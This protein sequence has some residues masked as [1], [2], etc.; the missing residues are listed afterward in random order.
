MDPITHG[1][2][3]A[4]LGK[5][6]FS[7]RNERVAIFAATLGAVFPDIDTVAD[8][9]S[10]DPLAIVKYHRAITHSFVAL[11]FFALLL[12]FLTPP[13]LAFLKRRYP[14]FRGMESPSRAMLTLI[15]GIGIASHILLDGMTS[16]GTRMWYPI[17]NTRVAWDLV[18][19][20]DLV[21][22]SIVL[23]PQVIAWIYRHPEKSRARAV[24]MWIC[25]MVGAVLGRFAASLAGYPFHFWIVILAGAILAILF[26]APAA[27]DWGF[28]I[29][30]ADWCV[31][32]TVLMVAYIFAC[33]LAHHEAILRGKTFADAHGITAERMAALPIPP[34]LLDWGDAIRTADGVYEAH[35]DLRDPQPP[36]FN[37]VRDSAPDFYTARAFQMSS[38]RL[39]WQFARFP[40]IYS[41][42]A[43]D[44]HVVVLGENRFSDGRRGPQ[45][46]TYEVK[47]DD[48]GNVLHEGWLRSSMM[49]VPSGTPLRY[50]GPAV[51]VAPQGAAR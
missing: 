31:G 36:A 6:F 28:R 32:G 7:K 14:V 26:F 34:S 33:A 16:F 38:V 29:S 23:L 5:G 13:A 27:G 3:G 35:F 51:T 30:R 50:P 10:R 22:T 25:F 21:F 9:V 47:F 37:F 1:I 41:Y 11:P 17:S 18:F 20:I 15:Y 40:S 8:F 48:A 12:A 42:A 4:L 39:Y 2:T 44:G 45:P 46:F 49:P 19:I 43:S 24:S